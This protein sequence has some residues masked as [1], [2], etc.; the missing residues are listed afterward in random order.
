LSA[1]RLF[2]DS[3]RIYLFLVALSFSKDVSSS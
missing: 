3:A 2:M 1:S